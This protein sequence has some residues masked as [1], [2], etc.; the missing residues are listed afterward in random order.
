MMAREMARVEAY[1]HASN[2]EDRAYG[3]KTKF[4]REWQEMGW[5]SYGSACTFAHG[6]DEL[7]GVETG[8]RQP[9]STCQA[10]QAALGSGAVSQ[11]PAAGHSD[12][13][14]LDWEA[15]QSAWALDRSSTEQERERIRREGEQ[16]YK[17]HLQFKAARALQQQ[18][19]LQAAQQQQMLQAAQQQFM[20]AQH[21]QMLRAQGA[22]QQQQQQA[23]LSQGQAARD[24][25]LKAQKALDAQHAQAEAA[26]AERARVEPFERTARDETAAA[27]A[28]EQAKLDE[29]ARAHAEKQEAERMFM[30]K[31]LGGVRVISEGRKQ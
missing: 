4:C 15:P 31:F 10:S 22:Y 20:Y 29:A 18:Q 14:E 8:A 9:W 7:R 27:A 2:A 16:Q 21:Q 3:Y 23:L 24:R 25:I 6:A 19:M 1:E 26:A 28:A 30:R 12:F 17:A 11:S 13:S 5:C